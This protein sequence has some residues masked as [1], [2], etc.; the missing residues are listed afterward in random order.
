M[1]S[2]IRTLIVDDS[3]F[4]RK[5]VRE[6]LSRSPFIDVVGTARD[7]EEALDLVESLKP[8]VVTCDLLMPKCDGVT[9]VRRQME[10][11]PIP[12]LL[13]TAT[14]EDGE[15]AVEAMEAGA[16][17]IVRKPT[18]LASHEI[19]TIQSELIDKVKSSARAS[20]KG[21]LLHTPVLVEPSLAPHNLKADIVL[22]G[23]STG[24]PQ[25]IRRILA[26]LPADFPV[27]VAI[28]VH[29]PVGYTEFLARKLDE[30][31]HL[32]VVEA[33]EGEPL[34]AG[35]AVLAKAGRHLCFRRKPGGLVVAH[36]PTRPTDSPHRPSVDA[37]FQSGAEVFGERVLAVVM[38]GMGSDGRQGAAWVK[39]QGGTVLTEAEESCVVFGMPRSVVEAG[40]SDAAI[41]LS[42]MARAIINRI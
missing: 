4:V 17:D 15:M 13:L 23:L 40:L 10:R 22:I 41:P 26:A 25:A 30:I 12:I 14:P 7:G 11:R 2:I 34:V 38:T 1:S 24:G 42:E 18:A 28:V 37:L 9:F 21:H 20:M 8:D 39:A 3:A 5:V 35:R 29:M 19:L 27:P 32:T 33:T 16:V 6:M 31:S 36:L